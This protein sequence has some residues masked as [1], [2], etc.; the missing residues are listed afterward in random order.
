MNFPAM[1]IRL[2]FLPPKAGPRYILVMLK[3][4]DLTALF[5][6]K[7]LC[8]QWVL[9]CT[10]MFV[11]VHAKGSLTLSKMQQACWSV[12]SFYFYFCISRSVPAPQN[13][14]QGSLELF[15]KVSQCGCMHIMWVL[16]NEARYILITFDVEG[17]CALLLHTVSHCVSWQS[18]IHFWGKRTISILNKSFQVSCDVINNRASSRL[19]SP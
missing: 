11:R 6:M 3:G 7:S 13:I 2:H 9:T 4:I 1:G 5:L 17:I 8:G 18:K 15:F 12:F 16:I 19:Y 10:K 14:H